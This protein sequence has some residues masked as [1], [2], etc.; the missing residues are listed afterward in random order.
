MVPR[1]G[2]R[3]DSETGTH[4][5]TDKKQ[6]PQRGRTT[7]QSSPTPTAGQSPAFPHTLKVPARFLRRPGLRPVPV[8]RPGIQHKQQRTEQR[9]VVEKRSKQ[10]IRRREGE[11]LT[12]IA[13]I[14]WHKVHF[15]SKCSRTHGENVFKRLILISSGFLLFAR[16]PSVRDTFASVDR[17]ST[18]NA[19]RRHIENLPHL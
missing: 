15:G 19:R 16:F 4:S 17:F 5:H 3:E 6:R 14:V 13:M 1:E 8:A 10:R 9:R 2:P 11:V 12:S 18:F 7:A